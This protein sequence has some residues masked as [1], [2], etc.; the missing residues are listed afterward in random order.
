MTTNHIFTVCTI[1]LHLSPLGR[2]LGFLI[3][4]CT[5]NSLS[6]STQTTPGSLLAQQL[7]PCGAH[8]ATYWILSP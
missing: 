2:S 8:S 7:K 5:W 3:V 4:T 1:Y 6:Y